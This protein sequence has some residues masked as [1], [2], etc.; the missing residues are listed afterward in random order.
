MLLNFPLIIWH[1]ILQHNFLNDSQWRML[2][3]ICKDIYKIF[4]YMLSK[5]NY[6]SKRII[7]I[8]YDKIPHTIYEYVSPI[9]LMS[10][11]SSHDLTPMICNNEIEYYNEPHQAKLDNEPSG[12]I[13]N[14]PY[15]AKL[16]KLNLSSMMI[17]EPIPN[18]NIDNNIMVYKLIGLFIILISIALIYKK[19]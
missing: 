2:A 4:Q 13:V 3:E 15:Q 17:N 11:L 6:P 1:R 14:E 19:Y 5:D 8:P 18:D 7:H 10:R 16:D 9:S 12:K